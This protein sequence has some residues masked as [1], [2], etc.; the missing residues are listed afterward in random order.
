[1][2]VIA[3]L[4][5]AAHKDPFSRCKKRSREGLHDF[6]K[7]VRNVGAEAPRHLRPRARR[8]RAA[9][10]SGRIGTPRGASTRA[11][12]LILGGGILL[13]L[14][15][16]PGCFESTDLSGDKGGDPNQAAPNMRVP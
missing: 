12:I 3:C 4:H 14:V 8:R 13:S 15:T 16:L 1:M 11:F 5:S 2:A 10:I 6:L 7:Q 9:L